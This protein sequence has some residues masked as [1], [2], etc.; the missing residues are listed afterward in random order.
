MKCV[1]IFDF[2]IEVQKMYFLVCY[3]YLKNKYNFDSF[4]TNG[5]NIFKLEPN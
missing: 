5:I 2:L 3:L 4:K 1:S